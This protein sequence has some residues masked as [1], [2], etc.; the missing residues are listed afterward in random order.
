MLPSKSRKVNSSLLLYSR[1]ATIMFYVPQK[2]KSVIFLFSQHND[3][4]ISSSKHAKPDNIYN[5][6]KSKG[7]VDSVDKMLKEFSCY[8]I[9]KRWPFVLLTHIILVYI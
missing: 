2:N 7:A 1:N 9:S 8:R 6:N 3:Y 4:S 5:Y